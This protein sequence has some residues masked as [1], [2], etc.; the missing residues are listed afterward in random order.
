MTA[1]L[2]TGR[3]LVLV[4]TPLAV[5]LSASC[6]TSEFTAGAPTSDGGNESS[7]MDSSS[8][9]GDGMTTDSGGTPRD[10]A[11]NDAA[12]EG[13]AACPSGTHCVGG[14]CVCDPTSC[15]GCCASGYCLAG[16][17]SA[18]CGNGGKAC[19][20]CN[21]LACLGGVCNAQ[22]TPS[23]LASGQGSPKGIAVDAA[24][25][26]WTN[27]SDGRVM[28]CA[29]AGCGNAPTALATSQ[30]QPTGIAVGETAVY[31]ANGGGD[32]MAC[33]T[34]GCT[35]PKSI[36]TSGMGFS[37]IAVS[38]G[39]LFFSSIA[40]GAVYQCADTGCAAASPTPLVMSPS[41]DVVAADLTYFYWADNTASGTINRCTRTN[42][43]GT[44][45][46][47]A[48]NQSNPNGLAVDLTTVYW[49]TNTSTG[50]GTVAK[51]AIGGCGGTPTLL[52][53]GLQHP[54]G[55]AV[56]AKNVY[57]TDDVAGA[58]YACPLAGCPGM[59]APPA[60]ATGQASP[61]A[62]AVDATSVYWTNLVT[63]GSVMKCAK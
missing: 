54:V 14:S 37:R 46:A 44:V 4:S 55:V 52:A 39:D 57:W 6:I 25:A 38:L 9:G 12:H 36:T 63:A 3:K 19:S 59:A 13:C 43:P 23:E 35:A 45:T 50:T 53:K 61:S 24:N 29:L 18:A 28:R 8:G 31:W 30:N 21:G 42:C 40:A 49:V 41:A 22:C 60:F 7:L 26:Y 16:N 15:T 47:L 11:P 51:C 27:N 5:L 62:I 33:A 34:G 56:D 32:I 48:S 58:L 1:P 2:E 20:S 17:D 10:A